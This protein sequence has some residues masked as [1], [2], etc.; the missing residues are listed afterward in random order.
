MASKRI[1]LVGEIPLVNE[2]A[3][4]CTDAGCTV[5]V[6]LIE[7]LVSGSA[8]DRVKQD[9]ERADVAIDA[10]SES[11]ETKQ[12]IVAALDP[13]LS[14]GAL[15]L[16]SALSTTATL[17]GS[18]AGRPERVVGFAGLPPLAKGTLIELAAGLRTEASALQAACQFF[19]EIGL[20]TAIVKD[21]VGLV[22]PRIV[23]GLVNEAA[24]A[25][26]DGVAEAKDI[27][28]AMRLGTN[29]PRGPL[30]WGDVIGLDVVLSVLNGLHAETG[31]DRY[32]PA[33]IIRQYVRAGWLGRKVGRGFYGY[34]E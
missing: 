21:G 23:C 29:Y 15:L 5:S 3:H 22:L 1:L 8:L 6:Y 31:D 20:E 30:E 26:A 11:L 10:M 12:A 17:A 33:P 14:T 2:L 13:A 7:E 24:T 18:W 28:M 19:D 34:P 32:R 16:S 4:L 25:L 27:D 9:A